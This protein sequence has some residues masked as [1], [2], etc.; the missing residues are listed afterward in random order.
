M[1]DKELEGVKSAMKGSRPAS[2]QDPAYKITRP[3][4]AVHFA[5]AQIEHSQSTKHIQRRESHS[6]LQKLINSKRF[7]VQQSRKIHLGSSKLLSKA[8]KD[9]TYKHKMHVDSSENVFEQQMRNFS[10]SQERI[11]KTL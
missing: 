1:L 5:G 11:N 3:Q 4:S 2:P 7:E 6:S 10:Q 8:Q 9:F